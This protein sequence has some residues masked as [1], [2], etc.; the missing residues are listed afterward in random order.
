MTLERARPL[1]LATLLCTVGA[2]RATTARAAL[3]GSDVD[4]EED[5]RQCHC[6]QPAESSLYVPNRHH[7]KV[8]QEIPGSTVG[9]TYDCYSCHAL[10][11]NPAISAYEF[12]P[13]RDCIACHTASPVP[14]HHPKVENACTDCD[15]CHVRVADPDGCQTLGLKDWCGGAPTCPHDD[16]AATEPAR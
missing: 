15:A 5:C 2:I 9:Q 14:G 11:W 10:A 4:T 3:T 6:A 13:F 16:A 12:V 8:G 1:A 7:R